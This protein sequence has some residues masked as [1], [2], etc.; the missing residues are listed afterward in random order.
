MSVTT[1][2]QDG[3]AHIKMDD[4]KA[5]AFSPDHIAA[6][7]DAL[8]KAEADAEAFVVSGRPGRFSGGFD[9]KVRQGATPDEVA[10]L[11]RAGGWLNLRVFE[12]K[13]PS[14][15]AV[16]GHAMAQGAF[17]VMSADT[18]IGAKGNFKMGLPETAIGMTLPQ[19]GIELPRARLNPKYFTQAVIQAKNFNPEECVE[20][21]F[22]DMIVEPDALIKTALET[23]VMLA[24][25][26]QK[27]YAANKRLIR[28]PYIEAIRASLES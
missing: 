10:E 28:K 11:V 20:A 1:D 7:N 27:N 24:A 22:L 21:G 16:T 9:L 17:F 18:R 23:A 15:M 26:P 2:I 5:N 3:I 12:N 13:L 4:G 19:F 6:L 25:L 14:V 8:D